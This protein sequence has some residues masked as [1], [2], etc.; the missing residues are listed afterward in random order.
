M[1]R[2]LALNIFVVIFGVG[3]IFMGFAAWIQTASLLNLP[4][5]LTVPKPLIMM[6]LIPL[7]MLLLAASL[8]ILLWQKRFNAVYVALLLATSPFWPFVVKFFSPAGFW[9]DSISISN[10]GITW[11][12]API[13]IAAAAYVYWLNLGENL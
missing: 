9:G 4:E 7:A 10:L 11:I 6:G 3:S 1:K 5:T 13:P 12:W 2:P 8:T